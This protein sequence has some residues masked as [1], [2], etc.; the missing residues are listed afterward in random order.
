MCRHHWPSVKEQGQ[1]IRTAWDLL[2]AWVCEAKKM[3]YF[4]K[5][6]TVQASKRPPRRAFLLTSVLNLPTFSISPAM[7][8]AQKSGFVSPQQ[9]ILLSWNQIPNV[10]L[11]G[12]NEKVQS[13]GSGTHTSV[14]LVHSSLPATTLLGCHITHAKGCLVS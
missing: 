11:Y 2:K 7:S 14:Q 10:L 4:G 1:G 8:Q 9:L 13:Q 3:H 6:Q 5:Q 12:E